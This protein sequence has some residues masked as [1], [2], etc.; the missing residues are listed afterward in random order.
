MTSRMCVLSLFLLPALAVQAQW[1]SVHATRTTTETISRP[2]GDRTTTTVSDYFRS[3]AGSELTITSLQSPDGLTAR[4]TATLYDG[5][6]QHSTHWI[7]PQRWR[8]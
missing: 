6:V 1:R 7:T 5:R 4:K 8:T 3:K 2:G